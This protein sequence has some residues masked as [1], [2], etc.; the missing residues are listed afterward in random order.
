MN[1]GTSSLF[2]QI[3]SKSSPARLLVETEYRKYSTVMYVTVLYLLGQS[4][5]RLYSVPVRTGTL[6]V[7][8]YCTDCTCVRANRHISSYQ[9]INHTNKPTIN[10]DQLESQSINQPTNQS[11]NQSINQPID[12]SFNISSS[13]SLSLFVF[14]CMNPFSRKQ[15]FFLTADPSHLIYNVYF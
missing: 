10:I 13:L 6:L 5:I 9:S 3:L 1:H 14:L 7:R 12:R 4:A 2:G 15:I 8:S 11:I